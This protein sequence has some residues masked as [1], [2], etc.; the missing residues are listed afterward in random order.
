M[1]DDIFTIDPSTGA[2]ETDLTGTLTDITGSGDRLNNFLGDIAMRPDGLLFAQN[3]AIHGMIS[4]ERGFIFTSMILA[5]IG[6]FFIERRFFRAAFWSLAAAFLAT[7]G[8]IHAYD[9]TP[10][11]IRSRFGLFEAPEFTGSYLLLFLL[12]L[13]VGWWERK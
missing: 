13:A 10:G 2:I 3:L 5:A 8:I 6:V 4:L 1:D 7:T 11:G 12:F 9:I